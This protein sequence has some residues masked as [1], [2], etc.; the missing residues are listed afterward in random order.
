MGASMRS[1]LRSAAAVRVLHRRLSGGPGGSLF[2]RRQLAGFGGALRARGELAN[3]ASWTLSGRALHTS[4]RASQRASSA[5]AQ[6]ED[7]Y[8]LLGVDKNAT[9]GDIKKAYYT[10]AKKLHPDSGT[11]DR[12]KFAAVG[13]AY[14]VL[15]DDKKR[16]V[17]D[18]YGM[19]GIKAMNAGFDPAQ[20]GADG[21]PFGGGGMGFDAEDIL[22]H[23][24]DMF[25]TGA[26]FAQ[27]RNPMAATRGDDVELRLKLTFMEAVRGVKKKARYRADVMCV[28]CSG[29]GRTTDTSVESCR[30]C[31]GTGMRTM[32][33]NFMMMQSTCNTCGGIGKVVKKPCSSCKGEGTI[34]GMR[35][36]MV[37][38]PA[39]VDTGQGVSVRGQG[40]AGARG[41]APGDLIVGIQVQ[42]DD[43]FVRQG[44]D[45]HVMAPISFPQA[46]LGG[47]VSVRGLYEDQ[48]EITVDV[49]RGTQPDN[50]T[51][52]R[53]QGIQHVHTAR[54]RGNMVVHFK[55][56]VPTS[57]DSKTEDILRKL[58][59]EATMNVDSNSVAKGATVWKRFR[60]FMDA[61]RSRKHVPTEGSFRAT[62]P[63]N[64]SPGRLTP[65]KASVT[66]GGISARG[67][68]PDNCTRKFEVLIDDLHSVRFT[69]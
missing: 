41:G 5:S 36:T 42:P 9:A 14:E 6:S 16:K 55:L 49:P 15:S 37:D 13:Q 28:P 62:W 48:S 1:L 53:D 20:A 7:L 45:V 57:L 30:T 65:C 19:E 21:N 25:G 24:G 22:R 31:N 58:G 66:R 59:N 12:E 2:G 23:F 26:G 38:I 68:R 18:S 47:K 8:D 11:G 64:F 29:S 51:I 46:A 27:Q 35:E 33:R 4:R 34:R 69:R 43:Y 63:N 52:V 32:T 17:Y 56:V 54:R 61:F 44:N 10:L 3:D 67:L 39:G 60:E 50:T 40:N